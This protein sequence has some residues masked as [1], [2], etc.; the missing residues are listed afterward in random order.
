[1]AKRHPEWV[2]KYGDWLVFNPGNYS[3][4]MKFTVKLNDCLFSIKKGIP[5]VREYIIAGALEVVHNYDIDAIHFDDYFYPYPIK[6]QEFSDGAAFVTNGQHFSDRSEWRR[7]NTNIL[8]E[9]LHKRI[10]EVKP[11]VKLGVSP[12]GVWRN[13]RTDSTGSNTTAGVQCYDDLYADTRT[14]IRKG[15][16]DYIVPQIYW[17]IGFRPASYDVLVEWWH[18]EVNNTGVHLYVGHAVTRVGSN[19]SVGWMNP[20]VIEEGHKCS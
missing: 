10:R 4:T 15:W 8:I 16:I 12:F 6:G 3:N 7:N 19:G 20:K 1:M 17:L 13:I 11:Y 14:W 5:E 9:E 18:R 2:I